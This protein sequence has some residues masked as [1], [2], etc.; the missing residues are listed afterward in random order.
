MRCQTTAQ[1]A[2][3]QDGP[4]KVTLL[5][6]LFAALHTAREAQS[7]DASMRIHCEKAFNKMTGK[8]QPPWPLEIG[9][10]NTLTA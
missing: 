5:P 1:D 6:S 9:D 2:N 7:G 10:E 4:H 8:G 3:E